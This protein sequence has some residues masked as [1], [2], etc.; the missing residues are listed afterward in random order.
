M[1]SPL[2]RAIAAAGGE[3]RLVELMRQHLPPGSRVQRGHLHYWRTKAKAGVP[4]EYC[5]PI[6][7]AVGG[8]VKAA[9][10]RPD[11]FGEAVSAGAEVT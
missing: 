1:D 8:A 10:L 3:S 4:A 7:S 9:E 6:E 2:N 11:I 5:R